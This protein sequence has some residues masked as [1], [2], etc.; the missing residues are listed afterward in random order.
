LQTKTGQSPVYLYYFDQHPKYPENSPQAD[1]GTPHGVD[2]AYVF[3][4][5]DEK[6]PRFTP[7]DFE[8]SEIMGTCWTNFA[9]YG[10]PNGENVPQWPVFS[11]DDPKAMYLKAEPEIGHVPGEAS[12]WVMD[13][14]FE[15]RRTTKGAEWAK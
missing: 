10:N 1:H 8:I 3:M 6:N 15:W 5:L 2:V 9:K 13:A 4:N 7:A 12:L 11:N 14:Y